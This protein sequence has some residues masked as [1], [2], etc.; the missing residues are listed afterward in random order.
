MAKFKTGDKVRQ[1]G[2]VS[3]W[4]VVGYAIRGALVVDANDCGPIRVNE[5]S[6]ELAPGTVTKYIFL[7]ETNTGE[8]M[9]NVYDDRDDAVSRA[10]YYN[11]IGK[12]TTPIKP[13][14]VE[15]PS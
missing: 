8:W 12:R 6:Y 15:V 11:N 13:Y 3:E 10:Q 5:D 7:N 2:N 1:K 9:S 4:H 14:T